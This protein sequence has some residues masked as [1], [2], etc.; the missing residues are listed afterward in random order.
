MLERTVEE[1]YQ[2]M[3]LQKYLAKA[4][5]HLKDYTDEIPDKV[6]HNI[7]STHKVSGGWFQRVGNIFEFANR[8]GFVDDSYAKRFFDYIESSGF[9]N[10]LTTKEDIK[11]A[12]NLLYEFIKELSDLA[13]QRGMS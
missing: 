13:K 5:S 2:N 10:R 8:S 4:R 6:L 11:F 9:H 3:L 1:D 7:H 12:D